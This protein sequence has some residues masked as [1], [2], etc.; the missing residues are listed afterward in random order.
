MPRSLVLRTIVCLALACPIQ[1]MAEPN[2]FLWKKLNDKEGIQEIIT[3]WGDAP[4][5]LS[6]G[7]YYDDRL[8]PSNA[9]LCGARVDRDVLRAF[10]IGLVES[11]IPIQFIGPF[12]QAELNS[13]KDTID[14]RSIGNR[15]FFGN[16]P[17]FS[18]E[19]VSN[20]DFGQEGLCGLDANREF[21]GWNVTP[22]DGLPGNRE[23]ELKYS[24]EH[25]GA[26]VDRARAIAATYSISVEELTFSELTDAMKGYSG[27]V[28]YYYEDDELLAKRI[29]A[30][31]SDSEF[32]YTTIFYRNEKLSEK[33][34]IRIWPRL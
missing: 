7:S 31:L 4:Y 12:Y 19:A 18:R 23:V 14:V 16:N 24:T 2:Y 28:W 3:Q 5:I 17:V 20:F 21:P 1:A 6:S 32:K 33:L 29:A 10:A 25:P 34:P 27:K 13:F 15:S 11:G 30:G 26:Y 22:V 9:I 8:L